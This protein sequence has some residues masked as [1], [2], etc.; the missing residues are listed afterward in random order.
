VSTA[1]SRDAELTARAGG[2]E[3][4]GGDGDEY[5]EEWDDDLGSPNKATV[6]RPMD[7]DDDGEDA[8]A[9]NDGGAPSGDSDEEDV[10]AELLSAVS[11]MNALGRGGARGHGSLA[12]AHVRGRMQLLLRRLQ[13]TQGATGPRR[14]SLADMR[15]AGS[16][17]ALD[18]SAWA[19]PPDSAADATLLLE[20]AY[21]MQ[22]GVRILCNLSGCPAGVDSM[23]E[24]SSIQVRGGRWMDGCAAVN[25]A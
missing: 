18:A 14:T 5:E 11:D 23:L 10:D 15:N 12:G 2:D 25:L 19:V 13:R 6:P 8:D 3:D 21:C 17:N 22:V 16:F 1:L 7:G 20:D 9:V 4:G 24:L